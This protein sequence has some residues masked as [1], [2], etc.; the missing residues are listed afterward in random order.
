VAEFIAQ[1]RRIA[2]VTVANVQGGRRPWFAPRVIW[3]VLPDRTIAY[4]DSTAYEINLVGADGA[5]KGVLGRPLRP[6]AVTGGIR[7]A[8][9]GHRT[10]AME[11]RGRKSLAELAETAP[12]VLEEMR[13]IQERAIERI[14]NMEFYPEVPVLRGLRATWEGSLWVQRRGED[15]LDEAGPIDVLGPDGEYRGTFAPGDPGMPL[16][17]GPRGLVAFLELDELDVAT[18]VVKRLPAEVR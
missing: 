6:E 8:V 16:A 12:E 13:E 9:I 14:R 2:P 1:A 3:D 10:E 7:A 4:F 17:F 18:I 5:A 15:P 11:E